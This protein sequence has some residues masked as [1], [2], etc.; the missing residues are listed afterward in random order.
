MPSFT[1]DCSS[2][3][4]EASFWQAYVN[5]TSPDGASIFGRNLDAFW[6]AISGGGPGWP[7][8]CEIHIVNTESLKTL[9]HGRFYEALKEMANNSQSVRL[10]VE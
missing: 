2:V 9:R 6:D 3:T 4:D 7:G 5:E 1:I 8:E 10:Y